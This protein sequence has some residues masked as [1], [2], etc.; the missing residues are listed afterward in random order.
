[1]SR[2]MKKLIKEY[3]QLMSKRPMLDFK[4]SEVAELLAL[5]GDKRSADY[6]IDLAWSSIRAGYMAGWKA[7]KRNA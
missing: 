4:S 5:A 6:A 7:A 3:D 2:D 1:M